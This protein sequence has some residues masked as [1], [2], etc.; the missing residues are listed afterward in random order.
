MKIFAIGEVL[1]DIYPSK[2]TLGGAALNFV[3]HASQLGA[4]STLFSAVGNDDLGDEV[5]SVLKEFGVSSKFIKRAE[6]PTGRVIVT[7]DEKGIPSYDVLSG[8]AYD[9][10][11]V[12]DEDIEAINAEGFDALYF[13]TLIQRSPVSRAAVKKIVCEAKFGEIIC[14]VNLRVNCYD[15][16]SVKFCLE[17]ATIL[18]VSIEEEPTL[19]SFGYYSPADESYE[20]IA[21][22]MCAAFSNLKVVILTLGKEGSYAYDVK[23]GNGYTQ[24]SIGDVVVSTVGAGDSFAAAWLT[25]YL[26]GKR[27]EDCMYKAAQISGFVVAHVEAVPKY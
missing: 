5:V 2:K 12:S 25:S 10:V 13:G 23:S 9:N 11:P 21:K 14:D 6:Q 1:W 7:L 3:A 15:A 4:A 22:A 20:A 27:I 26:G 8:M 19:R 16:E 17:N 18:K 24:G